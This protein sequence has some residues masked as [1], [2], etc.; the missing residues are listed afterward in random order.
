M[1]AFTNHW[2]NFYYSIAGEI[3]SG[4]LWWILL[5]LYDIRCILKK[6]GK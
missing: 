1:Y 5:E 2:I 6:K 3:V 4:V